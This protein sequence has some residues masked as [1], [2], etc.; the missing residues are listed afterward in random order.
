MCHVSF[1]I[2]SHTGLYSR[3]QFNTYSLLKKDFTSW[4]K[5]ARLF[6]GQA[7][8]SPEVHNVSD[9]SLPSQL[10]SPGGCFL[11]IFNFGSNNEQVH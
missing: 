9:N 10:V 11:S 4:V 8:Q 1:S 2:M 6:T 5:S 7:G 3:Q